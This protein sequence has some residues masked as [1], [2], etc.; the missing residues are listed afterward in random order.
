MENCF[1]SPC[2]GVTRDPFTLP[3]LA[4]RG[5]E[6]PHAIVIGGG[7]AGTTTALE[8][9]AL[10]LKPNITLIDPAPVLK[11]ISTVSRLTEIAQEVDVAEC[12]AAEWCRSR[13]IDFV[14]AAVKSLR[15][16]SVLLE[17]G[18]SIPF[19]TCCIA[20]GA[21][22]HVP[23]VLLDDRFANHVLT[24]RD[25][26]SI[27][28]LKS[29]VSSARRVLVV[30]AGGIAMEVVHEISGCDVVWLLR[31]H[32]GS[33]F[34]DESA[35]DGVRSIFEVDSR[36]DIARLSEESK[37][38]GPKDAGE[39]RSRTQQQMET[40]NT[41]FRTEKSSGGS[42]VGPEWLGKRA[43]AVFFDEKGNVVKDTKAVRLRSLAK[44]GGTRSVRYAEILEL[45]KDESEEYPIVAV[46]SDG[47]E[48]QCNVIIAGTGVI[49]KLSW[50][51]ESPVDLA[52][53]DLQ[54][55]CP[56]GV[57]V[58]AGTM[59]TSASNIFAAGDCTHVMDGGSNWFQMRLWTQALT[60]GRTAASS[61]GS[62]MGL[63]ELNE[64]LEFDVF[65]HATRFFGKKVVLLG[66][67]N[68]QGL[69]AGYCVYER[70]GSCEF[71]RVVVLDGVVRG[72]ILVG[73]VDCAE[74]FENLILT[75]M[76]V[77][78]LGESLVRE[79]TNL[80]EIFD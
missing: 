41:N 36:P 15:T 26:D 55:S 70:R 74:A 59:R 19:D 16:D 61:M 66:R 30:G 78:W 67:Y 63:C 58:S 29:K 40:E 80:D 5:K 71:V 68:A 31:D 18:I 22:P 51:K 64:G 32:M 60:A 48:E 23:R 39:L 2:R 6:I 8:L 43:G 75:E 4:M 65:A 73:D 69:R 52:A 77:G 27:A 76:N 62:C 21:S 35:A 7:V 20:T 56:G 49:P 10:S 12:S 37:I 17:N 14:Q 72:A 79:D 46:L 50:L 9:A 24:L 13:G 25:T 38:L 57:L 47:T 45:R 11:I 54:D 44:D 33:S 1:P 53:H 3:F 42:A 28:V 34:F